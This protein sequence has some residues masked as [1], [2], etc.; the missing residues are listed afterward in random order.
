MGLEGCNEGRNDL[1]VVVM[2]AKMTSSICIVNKQVSHCSGWQTV[3]PGTI[4]QDLT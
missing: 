2:R 4:E 1:L 3:I